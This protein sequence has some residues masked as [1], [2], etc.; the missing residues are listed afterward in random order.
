MSDVLLAMSL[1]SVADPIQ[2]WLRQ[3]FYP[4][5]FASLVLAS[6]GIPIPEDV[7]LIAAGVILKTHLGSAH[8]HWA[9]TIIV[10][11]IGV[12]AG[13]L[14]LYLLGR[15][16]GPDVV[17]HRSVRW[18]ISP[19]RFQRATK[20]FHRHGTW[21]CFF[22]RFVMGLRAAMC[23]AAGATRF[24]YWRFCLADLC[25]A[26]LSVPFFI[27]LG[28]VFA[29]MLPTL[30][31]YLMGAKWTLVVIAAIVILIYYLRR[32]A[33]KARL[34]AARQAAAP[35]GAPTHSEP[36]RVPPL[37]RAPVPV[38]TDCRAGGSCSG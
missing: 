28:Y 8:V 36:V 12:M 18:L 1:L 37:P 19:D 13:D 22:G 21:F 17:S 38:K 20:R 14:I 27:G 2:V 16:W 29:D 4:V 5:L 23:L 15:R 34:A 26:M 10:A 11:L 3:A 9:Q 7:P 32:R 25:G 35:A 31:V 6:L 30:K 24:P 33:R